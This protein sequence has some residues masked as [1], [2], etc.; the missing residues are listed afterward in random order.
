MPNQNYA[1]TPEGLTAWLAAEQ[2]GGGNSWK[3]GK[4]SLSPM[5]AEQTTVG[6]SLLFSPLH[7]IYWDRLSLVLAGLERLILLSPL[8]WVTIMWQQSFHLLMSACFE[9]AHASWNWYR[10]SSISLRDILWDRLS[11]WSSQIELGWLASKSQDPPLSQHWV[12][13]VHCVGFSKV[14]SGDCIGLSCMGNTFLKETFIF[15]APLLVLAFWPQMNYF[16]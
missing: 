10:V 9:C 8:P 13:G 11:P 15:L 5:C 6:H 12:L 14:S 3:L 1:K 16:L 2:P 4:G 7:F